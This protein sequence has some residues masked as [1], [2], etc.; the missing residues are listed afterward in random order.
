MFLQ[1]FLLT[2]IVQAANPWNDPVISYGF[3]D[4]KNVMRSVMGAV[5]KLFNKIIYVDILDA[6]LGQFCT[7]VMYPRLIPRCCSDIYRALGTFKGRI[8]LVRRHKKEIKG[9]Q[10]AGWS[11]NFEK[12]IYLN[13]YGVGHRL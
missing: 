12:E 4:T 5:A 9:T 10:D 8:L 6:N 13:T 2:S 1:Y 3:W 11:H 7:S